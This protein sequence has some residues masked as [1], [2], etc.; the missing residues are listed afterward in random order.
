MGRRGETQICLFLF[1]S[2][3]V[4]EIRSEN[5]GQDGH[6]LVDKA[7]SSGNRSEKHA[8]C[9]FKL[10]QCCFGCEEKQWPLSESGDYHL[11]SNTDVEIIGFKS[12]IQIIK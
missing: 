9:V 2:V 10:G 3:S 1:I 6:K 12:V 4:D 11:Q 7:S 8:V 5:L